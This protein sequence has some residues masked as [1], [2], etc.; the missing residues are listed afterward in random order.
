MNLKTLLFALIL[1]LGMF[2]LPITASAGKRHHRHSSHGYNCRPSYSS[3][4]GY[5]H[6]APRIRHYYGNSYARPCYSNNYYRRGYCNTGYYGGGH[7]G[8]GHYGGGHYGG[9]YYG[10]GHYGGGYYGNG[11]SV[12]L[13]PVMFHSGSSYGRCR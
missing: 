6:Y 8:G 3:G 1:S 11:L 9:G 4:Y 10:G 13:G 12:R 7:Y 5:R 2:S